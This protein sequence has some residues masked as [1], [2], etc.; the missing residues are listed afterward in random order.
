M[1]S[2][3]RDGTN[4]TFFCQS[5]QES[6]T[7]YVSYLPQFCEEFKN[8][9]KGI[10]FFGKSFVV[11]FFGNP[12]TIQLGMIEEQCAAMSTKPIKKNVKDKAQFKFKEKGKKPLNA[13]GICSFMITGADFD[14]GRLTEL[15]ESQ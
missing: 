6:P 14:T 5:E 8:S 13:T 7:L 12:D 3:L 9:G 11:G 2:A 4:K 1:K 15:F 10:V